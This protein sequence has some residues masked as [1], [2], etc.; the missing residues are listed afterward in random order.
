MSDT[1]P[2]SKPASLL[3]LLGG[4]LPLYLF[5]QGTKLWITLNFAPFEERDV[6]PWFSYCYWMNT[7][8]AFSMGLFRRPEWNNYVF[9]ALSLAALAGLLVYYRRGAFADRC[10]QWGVVFLLS[11]ILGNLTDRLFRGHVVDFLLF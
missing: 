6:Q 2:A 3:A 9:I 1:P 8:A 11:G 7:E 5:D 4:V 10:S